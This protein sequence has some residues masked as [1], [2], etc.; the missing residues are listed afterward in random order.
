MKPGPAISGGWQR[1][2]TSSRR[3]DLG[4]HVPR[5]PAQPLAQRHGQIGLVIAELRVLA[6]ADQF[7][8]LGRIVGHAGQGLSETLFQLGQD[9]HGG[10][11]IVQSRDSTGDTSFRPAAAGRGFV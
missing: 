1:S 9:A 11:P 2:A 3:D 8:Q 7:Q 4:G 10:G 6:A 5:R